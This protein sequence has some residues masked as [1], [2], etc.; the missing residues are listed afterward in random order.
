MTLLGLQ[1]DATISVGNILTLVGFVVGG[2]MFVVAVRRD[3]D[4]LSTRLAPLEKAIVQLTDILIKLAIQDVR[5]NT[6]ER[7]LQ[8]NELRRKG[9]EPSAR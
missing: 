5:L 7:D 9:Q 2:I 3:V 4:I 1:V 6:M 8:R